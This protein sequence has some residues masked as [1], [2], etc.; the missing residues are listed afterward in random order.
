MAERDFTDLLRYLA[1]IEEE[2]FEEARRTPLTDED[3]SVLVQQMDAHRAVLATLGRDRLRTYSAHGLIEPD[4]V[5]AFRS[6]A[7]VHPLT[8]RGLKT[9]IM[10]RSSLELR[11]WMSTTPSRRETPLGQHNMQL[12]NQLQFSQVN[13]TPEMK[14][15][16]C[17]GPILAWALVHE[18]CLVPCR[19]NADTMWVSRDDIPLFRLKWEGTPT[20]K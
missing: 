3:I 4:T 13:M 20:P 14:A 2:S 9:L 12:F 17:N 16:F 1:E 15:L 7:R 11:Y 18:V 5:F 19:T 10:L 6:H 8:M